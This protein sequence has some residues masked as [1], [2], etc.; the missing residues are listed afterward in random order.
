MAR[1]ASIAARAMR[2]QGEDKFWTLH[3]MLFYRQTELSAVA[4]PEDLESFAALVPGADLARWR[5]D[6]SDPALE[7]SI[8]DD[9]ALAKTLG[10]SGTPTCFV[11]GEPVNG[12]QDV[13]KFAEV[14]DRQRL[15]AAE[16]RAKGVADEELYTA[17]TDGGLVAIEKV[18][19]PR[20]PPAPHR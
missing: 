9:E 6:L 20:P 15:R 13:T 17:L 16:L 1:P 19:K 8:A 10:V 7:K 11:N 3:S 12:S 2:L 4:K 5:K 18:V 14:I